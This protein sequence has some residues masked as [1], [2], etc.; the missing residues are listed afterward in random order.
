MKP[1]PVYISTEKETYLLGIT[2]RSDKI[3]EGTQHVVLEP[4]LLGIKDFPVFITDT[5]GRKYE[6]GEAYITVQDELEF[7]V[8]DVIPDRTWH[9]VAS[10]N[11]CWVTIDLGSI[12]IQVPFVRSEEFVRR[13][14]EFFIRQGPD[15]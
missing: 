7:R 9:I 6:L 12:E 4:K 11:P 1:I 14:N 13:F 10:E 2:Y 15:Y 5:F 3:R 8:F